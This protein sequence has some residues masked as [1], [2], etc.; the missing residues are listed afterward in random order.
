[1]NHNPETRRDD[2]ERTAQLRS[3]IF[4]YR[5]MKGHDRYFVEVVWSALEHQLAPPAGHSYP[6]HGG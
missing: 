5:H 1:M 4:R 3:S 6:R 2:S